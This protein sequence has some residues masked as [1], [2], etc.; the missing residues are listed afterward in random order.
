MIEKIKDFI[1][2]QNDNM[3]VFQFDNNRFVKSVAI[4][5]EENYSDFKGRE[6]VVKYGQNGITTDLIPFGEAFVGEDK[7]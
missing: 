7:G 2:S 6:I 4:V 5:L 1:K 3:T